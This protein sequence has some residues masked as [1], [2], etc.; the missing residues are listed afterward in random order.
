MCDMQN[1]TQ[2]KVDLN[3]ANN[4][5]GMVGVSNKSG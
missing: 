1:A 4:S 3:N 5:I 2:N